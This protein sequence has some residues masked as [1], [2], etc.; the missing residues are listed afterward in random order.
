MHLA[1]PPDEASQAETPRARDELE[2]VVEIKESGVQTS[3][4]IGTCDVGTQSDVH[5][6]STVR[7]VIWTP[8]VLDSVV[9]VAEDLLVHE[10]EE[11]NVG[12][13]NELDDAPCVDDIDFVGIEEGT[14]V[15][16]ITV[17]GVDIVGDGGH[18][19]TETSMASDTSTPWNPRGPPG[20][21]DFTP[22][23]ELTPVAKCSQNFKFGH[24]DAV[25]ET[26]EQNQDV[27]PK[28]PED[29]HLADDKAVF[30]FIWMMVVAVMQA[31]EVES[32]E[33]GPEIVDDDFHE[34]TR[35]LDEAV[36]MDRRDM[37][38]MIVAEQY[39][40]YML[41]FV[42]MVMVMLSFKQDQEEGVGIEV[43]SLPASSV[44]A[45]L[46]AAQV[47]GGKRM[48]LRRGVT[49]DSGAANNVM[50]RRMVRDK[51]KIRP[52]PASK[53]GVYYVAAN[54]GRIPNEGEVDFEFLTEQGRPEFLVMQIAEV[55]KALGS[56]SYM[57]D[58]DFRVVFDKDKLTG[59]DLS[60]MVHKPTGR[61]T[62]FRRDRNV[63]VLDAYCQ[64]GNIVSVPAETDFGR[65]P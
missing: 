34:L 42:I 26:I 56:V 23:E 43:Y 17:V 62:R 9:D 57:V 54:N 52:S 45:K 24:F 8:A 29:L 61:T 51:T 20:V 47:V 63:W 10:A 64:D 14:T 38:I 35:Y 5:L 1:V 6:A 21:V 59:K 53:R 32:A 60:M 44:H 28:T 25:S 19:S 55:N 36:D 30:P 65:H 16:S 13:D 50:P 33:I 37:T 15:D 31:D 49:V 11:C 40:M 48:R 18:E 58:R 22:F 4:L 2:V 27:A 41:G 7:D 3:E 46:K 39:L 12:G